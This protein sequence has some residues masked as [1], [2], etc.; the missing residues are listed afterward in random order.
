[1][2]RIIT[3]TANQRASILQQLTKQQIE[4]LGEFTRFTMLSQFH[5]RHYLQNTDWQFVGMV[6]DPWYQRAHGHRGE[7]LY[8]DCG[9]RLKN[10]FILRSRSTGKQL[11]L[12]ITHFQQHASIPMTVAKEIQRGINEVH[13]Y[14]DS[15]LL[16]YRSGQRFPEKLFSYAYQHGGFKNRESTLLFQRCQLFSQV[17][18]PLHETDQHDLQILVDQLKAG[19]RPRLT[20]KQIQQ[21]L[22]SI[23]DDWRQI[24]QQIT[25]LTYHLG[26]FGLGQQELHRVKSN[27][28]NYSLQR[29]KSRFLVQNWKSFNTLTLTKARA[30]LAIKL[31]ELAFYVLITEPLAEELKISRSQARQILRTHR[32]SVK[33][34]HSFGVREARKFIEDLSVTGEGV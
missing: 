22:V 31:R 23:A 21:L 6:V 34:S 3:L 4:A 13:L 10:Q 11:C 17:D 24:E 7:N 16:R 32:Y 27:A 12:G 25:L 14:M 33:S 28:R 29:R 26:E 19:S 1:M 8:C 2:K 15:I 30:Q 18:L 5:T 20:K 9:R